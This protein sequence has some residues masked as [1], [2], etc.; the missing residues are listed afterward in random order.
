MDTRSRVR[1]ALA[2]LLV[3]A[4]LWGPPLDVT[5]PD[6]EYRAVDLAAED[7][8]LTVEEVPKRY[9]ESPSDQIACFSRLATL[10][11]ERSCYL[12]SRLRDGDVAVDYPPIGGFNGM[13]TT[14]DAPYVAFGLHSPVYERTLTYD[15]ANETFV[16][17]LKR[18]DPGTA[19]DDVASDGERAPPVIQRAIEDGSARRNERI[20][21]FHESRI[22]RHDGGYVLVYEDAVYDGYSEK[23]GV[24]RGFEAL[25]VLFGGLLLFQVGRDS[26]R[27]S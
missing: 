9:F 13:P 5:G 8:N 25:A 7:G 4:P 6:Y 22:Y 27:E 14:N 1:L 19:L 23:P 20:E 12:D 3:A 10:D 26:V 17:G 15:D 2:L 16:L 11:K 18:V 21:W 24:E